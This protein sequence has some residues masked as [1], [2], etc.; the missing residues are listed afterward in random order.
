[1]NKKVANQ[2]AIDKW[3]PSARA[4]KHSGT[5]AERNSRCSLQFIEPAGLDGQPKLHVFG[6]GPT[7]EAA[8]AMADGDQAAV[9][10]AKW[11]ESVK[12][13][14][15]QFSPDPKQYFRKIMMDKFN[16]DPESVVEKKE[17]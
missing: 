2:K 4:F 11:W 3:G 1:M 15:K 6:H 8:F 7:F 17:E 16:F 5:Q 14:F 9:D 10:F 13:E 12:E